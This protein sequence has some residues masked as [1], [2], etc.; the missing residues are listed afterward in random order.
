MAAIVN[1]VARRREPRDTRERTK[2]SPRGHYFHVNYLQSSLRF[3]P[4][5]DDDFFDKP[6][7]L[8][9]VRIKPLPSP[10]GQTATAPE[11]G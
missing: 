6:L 9:R 4:H 1:R 10:R 3:T 11:P 7:A 8:P 5:S 2:D